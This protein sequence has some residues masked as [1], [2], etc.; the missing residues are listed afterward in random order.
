MMKEEGICSYPLFVDYGQLCAQRE[1]AACLAVHTKFGLPKPERIDISGFG[2]LI[3]SGLTSSTKDV[4]V[5][6]FT[7]GR[8][9]LFLLVGAAY[10]FQLGANAVA[11][12]LL[13]EQFSLFP[14]Q[15]R[16]FIESAAKAIQSAMGKEIKVTTPLFEFSKGDVLEL[17]LRRGITGTYSC[18]K[19]TDKPCGY[20][21]SCL[22]ST[23]TNQ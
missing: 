23:G 3:I 10:A 14:D 9:L 7:P 18:H 5:D 1:W 19:G 22:E 12:G 8:N 4:N 20:C 16:T 13:S 21:I 11:I 6:A 2:K 17:A 15:K